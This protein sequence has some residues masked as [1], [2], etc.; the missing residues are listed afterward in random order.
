VKII[1]DLSK[2]KITAI[3]GD[4]QEPRG[5]VA[6]VCDE[7]VKGFLRKV[8]LGEAG[9]TIRQGKAVVGIPLAQ[10]LKLAEAVEPALLPPTAKPK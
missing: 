10:L 2:T 9:V 7:P 6:Q 8:Q 3:A 5:V 4:W 1:A